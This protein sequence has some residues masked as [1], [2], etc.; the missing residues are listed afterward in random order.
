MAY[1]P[2]NRVP[3]FP[4]PDNVLV[5]VGVRGPWNPASGDALISGWS[6]KIGRKVW[7]WTYALLIFL[8]SVH[9]HM[10]KPSCGMILK[11]PF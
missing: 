4:L 11:Y 1:W 10:R 2:Y 9:S 5:M 7:L 8:Q 3:D 6:E